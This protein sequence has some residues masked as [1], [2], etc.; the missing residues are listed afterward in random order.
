MAKHKINT[1]WADLLEREFSGEEDPVP[2]GAICARDIVERSKGKV[3]ASA[4]SIKLMKMKDAGKA[5]SI[6]VRRRDSA[7][8]I[9]AI[10]YYIL[11]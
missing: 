8:R 9:R 2:D 7:G 1:A 4:A 6:K 3:S 11:T 5:R 10:D